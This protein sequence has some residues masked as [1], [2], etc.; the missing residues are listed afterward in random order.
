MSG[1]VLCLWGQVSTFVWF[2]GGYFASTQPVVNSHLGETSTNAR[3]AL[4]YTTWSHPFLHQA[5]MTRVLFAL[6]AK[7]LACKG[8]CFS[9]SSDSVHISALCRSDLLTEDSQVVQNGWILWNRKRCAWL[10]CQIPKRMCCY[11]TQVCD[12]LCGLYSCC[13]VTCTY[14]TVQTGRNFRFCSCCCGQLS[15][16]DLFSEENFSGGKLYLSEWNLYNVRWK[17]IPISCRFCHSKQEIT[18]SSWRLD[19]NFPLFLWGQTVL[20]YCCL[21]SFSRGTDSHASGSNESVV[22]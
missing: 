20:C 18:D 4:P 5:T 12:L 14:A 1:N 19:H 2:V 11:Y 16:S 3:G 6:L 15:F 17:V 10:S 8:T 22:W 7:C 21:N 9:S 13:M